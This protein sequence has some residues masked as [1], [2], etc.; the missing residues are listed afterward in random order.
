MGNYLSQCAGDL[1][2]CPEGSSVS[3]WLMMPTETPSAPTTPSI[4]L[5]AGA[6]DNGFAVYRSA[7]D[8]STEGRFT[9]AV[10][11]SGIVQE[12]AL[13]AGTILPARWTNVGFS[14]HPDH[15]EHPLSVFVDGVKQ[16]GTEYSVEANVNS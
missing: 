4:V 7:D 1:S 2:K 13:S 11:H 8:G 14:W 5:L 3:M 12:V 15:E 6:A 9:V 10:V 16:G